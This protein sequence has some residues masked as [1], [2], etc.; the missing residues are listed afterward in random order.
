MLRAMDH[1]CFTI[2][3]HP[4][5]RLIDERPA[6]DIDLQ[7]VI[8]HARE[9]GCFLELN[10]QPARLDLDDL[11]CRMAKDEGVLVS[12]ATDAHSAAEFAHLAFGVGQARRGWLEAKD[13]LNARPLA[14]L[15]P[16]LDG[17][18]GRPARAKTRAAREGRAH[19]LER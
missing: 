1:P 6:C 17:A 8:R 10:A 12:I 13:V 16:L 9:R 15:R 4:T 18:M 3:A 11:A 7:R 2:L 5:G 14:Q 19:A